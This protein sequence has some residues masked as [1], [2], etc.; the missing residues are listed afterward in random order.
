[1]SIVMDSQVRAL[2]LFVR[3]VPREASPNGWPMD[4]NNLPVLG[5]PVVDDADDEVG[6]VQVVPSEVILT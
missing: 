6:P 3:Q 1:M 2:D 4:L 5:S